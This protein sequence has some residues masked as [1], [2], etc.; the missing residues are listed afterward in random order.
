[1]NDRSNRIGLK[2]RKW[3]QESM[4]EAVKLVQHGVASIA[5]ASRQFDIPRMTLSDRIK[6]KVSEDCTQIGRKQALTDQQEEDLC[7]FIDYMAGRG[8]PLTI[9]QILGYAW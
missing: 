2:H 4:N 8:F 5:E 1:M 9:H 3:S 7:K 6:H